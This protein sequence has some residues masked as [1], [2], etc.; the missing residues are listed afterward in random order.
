MTH[1]RVVDAVRADLLRRA[2]LGLRK[3]GVTLDQSPDALRPRLQHLYEELLDGANYVKGIIM[4]LDGEIGAE[5]K[6]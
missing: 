6:P 2:E 1:D 4:L 5:T 3:Y